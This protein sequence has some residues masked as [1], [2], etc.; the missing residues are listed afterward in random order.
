[1]DHTSKCSMAERRYCRKTSLG[2]CNASEAELER[3]PYLKAIEEIAR[4]MAEQ[5]LN[6]NDG[7]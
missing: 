4:L 5:V 3:C 1:M 6:E 7:K 2:C